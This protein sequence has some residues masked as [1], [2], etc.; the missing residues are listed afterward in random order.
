MKAKRTLS[1]TLGTLFLA[2]LA[3]SVIGARPTSHACEPATLGVPRST[4]AREALVDE[5]GPVT[6]EPVIG[7]DWAVPRSGLLNLQHPA[8]VAAGL[9]DGDEPIVVVLHALRHPSRG[10]FLVDTGIERALRDDPDHAAARG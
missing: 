6:V 3:A 5:P 10:L 8:A 9:R 4:S 2:G 1:L 7:G